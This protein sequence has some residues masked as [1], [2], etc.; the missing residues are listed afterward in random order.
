MAREEKPIIG[1]IQCPHCD[2]QMNVKRDKNDDPFGHCEDCRGQLRVGGCPSRLRKFVAKHPWAAKTA[3]GAADPVTV[4][5]TEKP[6]A[7]APVT[8]P[9]P[10]PKRK[11]N[12]A[13]AL[14][15]FA[16]GAKHAA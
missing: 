5:V 3:V 1:T 11:A 16:L 8:A 9:V 10:A 14:G 13:D 12:F 2:G 7:P 4:T 15:V 6:A